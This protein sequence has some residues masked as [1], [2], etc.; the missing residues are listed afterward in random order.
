MDIVAALEDDSDLDT[1]DEEL[2]DM[3]NDESV[4]MLARRL[5]QQIG[6][7]RLS[8]ERLQREATAAARRPKGGD[9]PPVRKKTEPAKAG[10]GP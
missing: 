3:I 4:E 9:K 8:M 6:T 7:E 2:I 1:D 5:V 10:K